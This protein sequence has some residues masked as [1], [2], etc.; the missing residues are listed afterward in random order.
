MDWLKVYLQTCVSALDPLDWI[1]LVLALLIAYSFYR[2]H[3]N[4]SMK[5]FNIFD[6]IMENGRVSRLACIFIATWVVF[7]WAVVKA[8][9]KN[10]YEQLP[11]YGTI[12]AIP[13]V[14]KMFTSSAAKPPE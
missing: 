10:N 14:A 5:E 7:T 4:Q 9:L 13:I 3:Q 8:V 12:W 1:A 11:L 2:A 6:L